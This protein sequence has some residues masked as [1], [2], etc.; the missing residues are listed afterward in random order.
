V[1]TYVALIKW[2]DQGIRSVKDTVARAAQN[3]QAIEG[4]GGRLLGLWW[5][6]GAYDLVAVGEWPDED[7]AMAFL[8]A[9]GMEG[10]VRTET[11]RA[12]S[13]EDMQ[14]ILAKLG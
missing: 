5:T 1:P 7:G 8:L 12:F 13:A 2:T 9:S 4:G 6:Q 11:L 10:S 14:R 3:R